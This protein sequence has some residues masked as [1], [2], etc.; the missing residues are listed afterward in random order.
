MKPAQEPVSLSALEIHQRILQGKVAVVKAASA[1]EVKDNLYRSVA[2]SFAPMTY[3]LS[4]IKLK[5]VAGTVQDVNGRKL[6]VTIYEGEAAM[7]TCYTFLGAEND[8][9]PTA[10]RFYAQRRKQISTRTRAMAST[11][12]CIA[13]EI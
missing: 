12:L 4:K 2:G 6:L 10:A 13:K 3:D 5:A 7:V 9:P 8:A 11:P 1:E